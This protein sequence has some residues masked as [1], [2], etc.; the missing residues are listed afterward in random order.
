MSN[1]NTSLQN[2]GYEFDVSS[3]IWSRPKFSSIAYN[4]GDEVETRLS[5]VIADASDLSV[6]SLELRQ[7]C[8]DWP[9]LYHLSGTRA[10][11]LRPLHTELSGARVLEVGA[12]CGAITRYLGETGAQVLAL[13]GSLRRANI[14]RSRTRDLDNVVVVADR[15]AEFNTDE[16]FD[17][18]TLI[19]VLEYANLFTP[20]EAPAVTM[21]K[22]VRELLKPG[23]RLVIAI[24]NQLGLK[25]LAGAP[26]DHVGLSMYG[27]EDLYRADQAQTFGHAVLQRTLKE[28]GYSSVSTLL[29][30]PD[31]KFPTSILSERGLET[32][33]F[34]S[35]AFAWQSVRR[36]PQFPPHINFRQELAWPVLF[37][38]DLAIP[39]SNS[40]LLIAEN[41]PSGMPPRDVLAY[42]FS[43]DRKPEFC[44]E[45]L[46][47]AR[48]DG[49][50]R[51]RYRLLGQPGTTEGAQ[52]MHFVPEHD[53]DY[54]QGTVMSWQFIRTVTR[55][56][57]NIADI[58]EFFRGYRSAL[59][60]ILAERGVNVDSPS[61]EG[62]LL[63]PGEFLDIIPQNLIVSSAG[64]PQV[65]DQEWRSKTEIHFSQLVF[66]S[67]LAMS[68]MVSY[69]GRP[70]SNQFP[71][72]RNLLQALFQKLQLEWCPQTEDD[73]VAFEIDIQ[74]T[75]TGT[76]SRNYFMDWLAS[77]PH[78]QSTVLDVQQHNLRLADAVAE[79]DRL[80]EQYHGEAFVKDAELA[81]LQSAVNDMDARQQYQQLADSI[82]ERNQLIEQYHA[83]S[84]AKDAELAQLKATVND[85]LKNIIQVEVSTSEQATNADLTR[86]NA[87]EHTTQLEVWNNEQAQI[88]EEGKERERNLSRGLEDS[89]HQLEVLNY[90][91]VQLRS[92]SSWKITAPLRFLS[93]QIKRSRHLLR[94]APTF[95]QRKGKWNAIRRV[96]AILWQEGPEGIKWRLRMLEGRSLLVPSSSSDEM[97]EI[98]LDY[99]EWIRRYDTLDDQARSK[100][101]TRIDTFS[102]VPK[103]SLIMP[104]YD[105]PLEFLDEAIRSVRSQLYP[106]WE[107]CIADDASKNEAV[108]ELLKKHAAEDNRIRLVLRRENGHISKASNSA[109]EIAQGD[110]IAMFDHDDLIPEHALYM[111]AEELNKNP[112]LDFLYSDQDKVDISGRRYDPYFKPDFNPDLLRSQN[113]VDHLAVFRASIA[114]GLGGW[115][116]AFDGS[117]DYDFVLRFTERLPIESIAHIP[118]VLYHWRA[119]PGSLAIDAGA[120]NYA[121]TRSRQALAEHLQRMDIDAEVTS[122][123]PHLSI[124]RVIYP[125]PVEPLV[126]IV[127]PTKDGVDILQQ[128]M[129]GIFNKT[130]YTN[131]EVIIVNNQSEKPETQEYF[132]ELLRDKRVRIIDFDHPFNYSR[133]NNIAVKE[134]N[135]SVLALLN[136]DL[137]VIN[138]D[139]LREMVSHAVR[140]EIGAVGARLFYPDGT[141]QHAGV[142]LGYK[143]RAGHMYRY[144]PRH[145]L[146]YWARA[147]LIQ[148]LTA[149]TAACLVL[150]KDVYDS[151][152]GFDEENFTITFNDVDLCLRIH[153]RGFRN[154]YTPYAELYH[155]ESKTRGLMAF[156]SEEDYFSERWKPYIQYDTAYN[157]NLSL[158]TEDFS[159]AFP[160]RATRPWESE[161]SRIS[162]KPLVSIITRTHGERQEFLKESIHSVLRQTYRPLQLV[163]VEDGTDNAR[164]VVDDLLLPA[165]VTVTYEALPKRGRCFAGNRG[166]E[167]AQG[168][169]FGFLDDDDLLLPDHVESLVGQLHAHPEAA[170]AYSSSW[171]IPTEVISLS[172][173]KYIEGKKSLFGRARFSID[174]LWNYNYIAIQ[175]LLIKKDLFLKHGGFSE[176]LDCLEDWDLWL[177]YTSE[178]DFVFLDK[179]TS[180]F[181]MPD[182]ESVLSGRRDQHLQYLPTLRKRQKE[183][184]ESH[185]GAYSYSRLKSAFNTIQA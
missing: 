101:L 163:I 29:P 14:A 55:D 37:D 172:P 139:W 131:F 173:L 123:Y 142:L 107:L 152:G 134:A 111:F 122:E 124:H 148:N 141:V 87:A 61:G 162:A 6:L 44:K 118:H 62:D 100:I 117:Q 110:F 31:Y 46:F 58:V 154:L 13:E 174:A 57:W 47:S 93:H 26:E 176:E 164:Q 170:A 171:E 71:T 40:F 151:I 91:I 153:E 108:R 119:V 54:C 184:L 39:L 150:R 28:G 48:P 112:S 83:N 181:R 113:F 69:F 59:I 168:E 7:H 143:G 175:S 102:W 78:N 23:G 90:E 50:I 149:V 94:L 53:A 77:E 104:V 3:Q 9:S 105:P 126:S 125:L 120:K 140:P 32:P 19:G 92:S 63:L 25:Y 144:A 42:H 35:S 67:M 34:D 88:I 16:R 106:H 74:E 68:G 135:G 99:D 86:L 80:I 15:F 98:K 109:L 177:R 138:S 76:S 157:P 128:C 4:D 79:R 178:H 96:L 38:N 1:N 103:F 5:Q 185:V 75:A 159:L 17:I 180:E 45:T 20:G 56:G 89:R 8:T 137:E 43:T 169:L 30:L 147:V 60:G 21:L 146:G 85:Q 70:A 127:I 65:I 72:W 66:R 155:H 182:N 116:T 52:A 167:L 73:L 18:I 2:Q 22:R 64:R 12:G 24:E 11:I 36:D 179:A 166:L 97:G 133:I 183:L 41:G 51:V 82:V 115:R 129:D 165:G 158:E 95:M 121:A 160:P 27:V 132:K 10:N 84:L 156:Q 114:R 49:S 161:S 136:N 33:S 81:Q 130:D 145:W